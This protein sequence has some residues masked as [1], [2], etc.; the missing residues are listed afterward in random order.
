MPHTF[1]LSTQEPK[2]GGLCEFRAKLVYIV[3]T[4]LKK[5]NTIN[6]FFFLNEK[7]QHCSKTLGK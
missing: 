7:A 3:G 6:T 5:I 4:S 1:N 2:A